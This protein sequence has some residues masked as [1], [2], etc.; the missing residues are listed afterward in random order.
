[1]F[2]TKR[3]NPRTYVVTQSGCYI[4]MCIFFCI[5]NL[6]STVMSVITVGDLFLLNIA[7]C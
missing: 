1:M 2:V 5:S 7:S 6:N 4:F 3:F